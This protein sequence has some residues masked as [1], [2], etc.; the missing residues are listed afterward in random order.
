MGLN[1]GVRL[2]SAFCKT[3]LISQ[4]QRCYTNN[5]RDEVAPNNFL[6]ALHVCRK[7]IVRMDDV[8]YFNK[9]VLSPR[10][11]FRVF[12]FSVV[13]KTVKR[14]FVYNTTHNSV[15]IVSKVPFCCNLKWPCVHHRVR[16]I[17][18]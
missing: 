14:C 6:F 10:E 4:N 3:A 17:C 8:V 16:K 2:L 9:Y 11:L 1:L 5:L 15:H 7:N 18:F 13:L 12:R